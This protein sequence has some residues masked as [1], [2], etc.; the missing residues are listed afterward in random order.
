M[1]R[2]TLGT[3]LGQVPDSQRRGIKYRRFSWKPTCTNRLR[4][5]VPRSNS[6]EFG[7][8]FQWSTDLVPAM[9]A[10]ISEKPDVR[11]WSVFLFFLSA[12]ADSAA[13][14]PPSAEAVAQ[15][16]RDGRS[17]FFPCGFKRAANVFERALS[18]QPRAALYYWL[19][20]PYVR[21]ADVSNPL[22]APKNARRARRN[23]EEVVKRDP[24]NNEYLLELFEFYADS[25]PEPLLREIAD[26]WKEHGGPRWWMRRAVLCTSDAIRHVVPE[27]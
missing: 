12:A 17:V 23:L 11:Y 16:E 3:C 27:R 25:D 7:C 10:G 2:Q 24:Q 18:M 20:K 1:T 9:N 15:L 22:S 5:V 14:G 21:L 6:S 13:S 4:T 8:W 26:S 19:G